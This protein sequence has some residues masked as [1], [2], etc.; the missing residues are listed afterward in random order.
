MKVLISFCNKTAENIQKNLMLLDIESGKQRYLIEQTSEG[1]TG[2]ARDKNFF[3]ALSQSPETGLV[4]VD[5]RTKKIIAQ[6]K[7]K[8]LSDPHSLLVDGKYLYAVST[9]NDQV[10]K[11]KF[12]KDDLSVKFLGSVWCPPGSKGEKDTYHVNSIAKYGKS[13][14]ISAFGPK[15]SKKWSSAKKGFIYDITKNKTVVDEIYHPH[16]VKVI[17]GKIFYCESSSRSV[18]D[19]DKNILI[20]LKHGY[21]RGLA[22]VGKYLVVGT[23]YGRKVSKSTGLINNQ[24]DPGAL[25]EDC[26][27]LVYKKNSDCEDYCLAKEFNFSSRHREIYY[28]RACAVAY[29]S[30]IHQHFF[31][32]LSVLDQMVYRFQDL[33]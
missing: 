13:I 18:R 12:D 15:K 7:L 30:L 14:Y 4:V 32:D 16:S 31:Q 3:Y 33:C 9:G 28:I 25:E 27:V 29:F 2:L 24:A 1:F 11:Y 23:S 22:F 5:R 19:G 6:R 26:R 10:L 8:N 21:T 17:K 20:K